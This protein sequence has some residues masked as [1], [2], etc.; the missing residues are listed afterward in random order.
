MNVVGLDD[1]EYSWNLSLYRNNQRAT[2]S[3]GHKKARTLLK[4]LFPFDPVLEE[5]T[6]PGI[7]PKL[8]ADFFIAAQMLMVEVQGR[9]HYEYVPF[10]H[11]TKHNYFKAVRR[12]NTKLSWCTKNNIL[13]IGLNDQESVDE[14]REQ[15]LQRK[16]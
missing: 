8:Y 12:D 13:L 4:E 10:F 9:Q 6:L 2:A 5:L 3:A 1:K 11:K 16:A 15:I 14:W 7:R